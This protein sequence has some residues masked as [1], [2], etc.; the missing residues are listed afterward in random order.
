MPRDI[1]SI[2]WAQTWEHFC[3]MSDARV[4]TEQHVW[5]AVIDEA[6]NQTFNYNNGYADTLEYSNVDGKIERHENHTM[7]TM[8]TPI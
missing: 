3:D 2:F 1:I 8:S 7:I 5:A 4:L 6:K